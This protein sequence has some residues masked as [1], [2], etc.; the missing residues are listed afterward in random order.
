MRTVRQKHV[1]LILD[2]SFVTINASSN[3]VK[4]YLYLFT[5]LLIYSLI[6]NIYNYIFYL[7]FR[8]DITLVNLVIL[9]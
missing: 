4:Q 5:A 7:N 3:T 2:S 9:N 1:T 6:I 8:V